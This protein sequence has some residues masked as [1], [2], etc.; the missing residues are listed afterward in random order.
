MSEINFE[1]KTNFEHLQPYSVASQSIQRTRFIKRNFESCYVDKIT[2]TLANGVMCT[3]FANK[4]PISYW[5][6]YQI[7]GDEKACRVLVAPIT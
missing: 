5:L 3:P 7:V 4:K 1:I 6:G 2:A